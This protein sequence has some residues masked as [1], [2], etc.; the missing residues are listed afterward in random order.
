[1]PIGLLAEVSAKSQK[2]KQKKKKFV[3]K[4]MVELFTGAIKYCVTPLGEVER[5]LSF[6]YAFKLAKT[7]ISWVKTE[8]V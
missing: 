1:M 2:T 7:A 8:K 6:K 5:D 4:F 3:K